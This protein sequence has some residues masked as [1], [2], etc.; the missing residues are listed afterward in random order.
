MFV[1]EAVFAVFWL[2]LA[3]VA[4]VVVFAVRIAS[5]LYHQRRV[6]T[7]YRLHLA[8]RMGAAAREQRAEAGEHQ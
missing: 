7:A 4:L 8:A 2:W 5:L 1:D 3:L 6:E